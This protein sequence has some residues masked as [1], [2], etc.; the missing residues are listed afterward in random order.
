M[1]NQQSSEEYGE[2]HYLKVSERCLFTKRGGILFIT[3]AGNCPKLQG[4]FY[5]SSTGSGKDKMKRGNM[6]A[7]NKMGK[8]KILGNLA[9][10][11]GHF[12]KYILEDKHFH[13][14]VWHRSLEK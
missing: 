9:A 14:S 5:N 12:G 11:L 1:V 8:K 10:V 3:W 4:S 6:G 13:A 2:R 7:V